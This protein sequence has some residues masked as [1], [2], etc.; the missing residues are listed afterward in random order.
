MECDPGAQRQRVGFG[1]S[2]VEHGLELARPIRAPVCLWVRR[3]RLRVKATMENSTGARL[4]LA[5][6]E[7]IWSLSRDLLWRRSS[8]DWRP[9]RRPCAWTGSKKTPPRKPK[10]ARPRASRRKNPGRLAKPRARGQ[11]GFP[12]YSV[13]ADLA[14]STGM[15]FFQKSFPDRFLDVAWPSPTWSAPGGLAKRADSIVTLSASSASPR[16]PAFDHG[17]A[18]AGPGHRRLFPCRVSGR[19]T[20]PPSGDHLFRGHLGHPARGGHRLLLRRRG[21]S[22]H[23]PGHPAHRHDRKAGRDGESVVFFV[24]RENYPVRLADTPSMNGQGADAG[25][26]CDVAII[27]ADL[28]SAAMK[29]GASCRSKKSK[30][31]LS[32]I[33]SSIGGRGNHWRG[34]AQVF[35]AGHHHRGPSADL[36]D[37]RPGG[38]RLALAGIA[39]A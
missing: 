37:G 6:G 35:G 4:P 31:R 7:K 36:R 17:R 9:G 33:R 18:L 11:E 25:Q 5:N 3:S 19:A 16:Q 2:G 8:A 32:A 13:S 26:R 23:V 29:P 24:G 12:V 39:S 27:A 1:L 15:S 10:P 22:A 38:P 14:G 21:G 28:C 20:G 34:G 30:P